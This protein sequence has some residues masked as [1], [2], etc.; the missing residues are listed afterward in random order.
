ML[1]LFLIYLF[2]AVIVTFGQT[3]FLKHG[4]Y[5]WTHQFPSSCISFSSVVRSYMLGLNLDV[6]TKCVS[7]S[8]NMEHWSSE[9]GKGRWVKVQR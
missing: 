1:L 2:I 7:L 6:G 9:A 4:V 8:Q 5:G 3:H